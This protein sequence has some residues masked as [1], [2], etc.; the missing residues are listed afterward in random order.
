MARAISRRDGDQQKPLMPARKKQ[1]AAAPMEVQGRAGVSLRRAARKGGGAGGRYS[2]MAVASRRSLLDRRGS[3]RMLF[4]RFLWGGTSRFRR[5]PWFQQG[6]GVWGHQGWSTAFG[7]A[8]RTHRPKPHPFFF[9]DLPSM[10]AAPHPT[11]VCIPSP[12][13]LPR[14]GDAGL[15]CFMLKS[16]T[17]R[18]RYAP[19]YWTRAQPRSSRER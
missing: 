9:C 7:E 14:A 8:A 18:R 19:R 16:L 11:N 13:S 3:A 15:L 1:A 5:T 10:H 6:S 2:A 17:L 4:L 12:T